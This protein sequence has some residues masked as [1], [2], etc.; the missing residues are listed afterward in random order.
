V[1]ADAKILLVDDEPAIR[2]SVGYM[3]RSN[4]FG[5][6][7]AAS[8]EAALDALERERFDVML[9]DVRLPRLSGV[10]LCRRVRAA[11]D[12]PILMLTAADAEV[13]RVVGL[14][15]GADDYVTKPFST[16]ELLSRVRAILR[17]RELDRGASVRVLGSLEVDLARH[18]ARIEGES[19]RLTPTEFRLLALLASEDRPF[20]RRE[21]MQHLWESS[22]VG[23]ER[24]ADVHVAN[25][26]RKLDRGDGQ[27]RVITVRGVGYRLVAI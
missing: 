3:L 24:A 1:T 6:E 15:A 22:Y 18:E 8:G 12:I 4:G 26:R 13:D 11:S 2:D 16:A 9:L 14:E 5:V 20:S 17:R 25:I 21:I 27:E 23:D 19:V 7:T 10:E